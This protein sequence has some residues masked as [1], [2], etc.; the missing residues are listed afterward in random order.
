MITVHGNIEIEG[1]K[2]LYVDLDLKVKCQQCQTKIEFDG[3]NYLSY[4]RVKGWEKLSFYCDSCGD[5]FLVPA[6]VKSC[7]L[8]LECDIEKAKMDK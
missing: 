6:F 3:D 7:K 2:R 5:Y 4:V 8:E 1:I